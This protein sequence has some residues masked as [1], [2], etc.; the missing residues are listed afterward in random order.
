MRGTGGRAHRPLA[1]R[2][3]RNST[4]E[5]GVVDRAFHAAAGTASMAEQLPEDQFGHGLSCATL[6]G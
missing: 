3:C 2:A 1:S 6:C 5:G 4:Q